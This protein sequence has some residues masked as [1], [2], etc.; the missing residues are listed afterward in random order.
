MTFYL[1]DRESNKLG[2]VII[3]GELSKCRPLM[4]SSCHCVLRLEDKSVT[5]DS[6]MKIQLEP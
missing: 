6:T 1:R 4:S 2:L 3:T 5:P